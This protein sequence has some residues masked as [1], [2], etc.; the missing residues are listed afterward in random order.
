MLGSSSKQSFQQ[1]I[2]I[3]N[4]VS[5]TTLEVLVGQL[6]NGRRHCD[7][8]QCLRHDIQGIHRQLYAKHN[9]LNGGITSQMSPQAILIGYAQ[10]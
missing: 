2:Q 5:K 3:V 7:V 1:F 10:L 6:C 9:L 4:V 8:S